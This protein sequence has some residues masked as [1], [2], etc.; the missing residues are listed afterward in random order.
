MQQLFNVNRLL[1]RHHRFGITAQ[2]RKRRARDNARMRQTGDPYTM[3]DLARTPLERY[4]IEGGPRPRL[5]S[6]VRRRER[7]H[8]PLPA[9]DRP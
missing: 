2:G 3:P 8:T 5:P 7:A 6:A 1:R 9:Q 4:L